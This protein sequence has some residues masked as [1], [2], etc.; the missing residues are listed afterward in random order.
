MRTLA[1]GDIHGSF[2]SLV[3]LVEAVGLASDDCL[4]ILGDYVDRGPASRQVIE[5]LID[6]DRAGTLVPIRGNH[7][8]MMLN[9]R[10]HDSDRIRW[11][12]YGGCETLDSYDVG[13][14]V[15]MLDDIPEAHWDFL[16]ERLLPFYQ[17]ES[18]L[19]VHA[20]V[21]PELSLGQQPESL[22]FWG[23]YSDC[24]S[25]HVSGKKLI[26]GHTSQSS[27]LP[28]I[29]E[30]A[31][32]IDTGACRGGWLTC[33]DVDTEHVWQSNEAG[34]IREMDLGDLFIAEEKKI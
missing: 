4:V 25:G 30:H 18:H 22:L 12:Q 13:G 29:G 17:S 21:D 23:R 32:C 15:A 19:F 24:F 7:E 14:R 2:R 16:G 26:C 20:T 6:W 1:I 27:G 31:I 10:L 34:E 11:G 9:A 5:W 8:I 3:T 33:L 28:A